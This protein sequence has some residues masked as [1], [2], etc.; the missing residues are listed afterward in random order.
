MTS[1]AFI[2]GVVPLWFASGAGSVARQIIGTTVI[3]GMLAASVG[4]CCSPGPTPR[5]GGCQALP[6]SAL[7]P[8]PHKRSLL[9]WK[10]NEM[11]KLAVLFMIMGL[12]SGCAVGPDYKRPTTNEPST[13][14]GLTPEQ[15]AKAGP[16]SLAEQKW[17]EVFQ[18]QQL[19]E[20][21]RT[22]LQQNYDVRIAVVR[23]LQAQAQLGITRADQF[24]TVTGGGSA[25]KERINLAFPR[26]ELNAGFRIH[27]RHLRHRLRERNVDRLPLAQP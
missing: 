22:A 19:Q 21:I 5:G 14:R 8:F 4:H 6:R 11:K 20:L 13:Y 17:W 18:D 16:I 9:P 1:F 15:A 27:H 12:V 3:G 2:L 26:L 7:Q 24:P 10:V 25:D 23:V